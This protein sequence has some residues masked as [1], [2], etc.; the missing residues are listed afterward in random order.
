[1]TSYTLVGVTFYTTPILTCLSNSRGGHKAFRMDR[2]HFGDG[3][4]L[5]TI[6]TVRLVKVFELSREIKGYM[7]SHSVYLSGNASCTILWS[8]IVFIPAFKTCHL[9]QR[10]NLF[11]FYFWEEKKKGTRRTRLGPKPSSNNSAFA[12]YESE[13]LITIHE[14][15]QPIAKLGWPV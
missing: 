13:Y 14:L 10:P 8:L 7:R 3:V 5:P 1:M 12:G 15:A 11:I 9:R 2:T 6:R 4:G